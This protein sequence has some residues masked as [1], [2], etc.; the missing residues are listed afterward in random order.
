MLASAARNANPA[1]NPKS[2]RP[3]SVAADATYTHTS[4]VDSYINVLEAGAVLISL[5]SIRFHSSSLESMESEFEG[6]AA[7]LP[8]PWPRGVGEYQPDFGATEA[9]GV[10]HAE[11]YSSFVDFASGEEPR[12]DRSV[13]A[14][15][16]V[17]AFISRHG[18][19]IASSDALALSG[20]IYLG[21]T[22]IK[23][24]PSARWEVFKEGSPE[25]WLGERGIDAQAIVAAVAAG[26]IDA[27]RGIDVMLGP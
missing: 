24:S 23:S 12:V 7:P 2:S 26:R 8:F 19:S 11:G 16:D 5:A 6:V 13:W 3:L 9:K 22:L 17:I 10:R 4:G 18:K 21:N 20:A 14:T 15:D 27:A 25:V 1:P